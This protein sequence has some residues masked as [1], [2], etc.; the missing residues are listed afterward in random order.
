LARAPDATCG[1]ARHWSNGGRGLRQVAAA[2]RASRILPNLRTPP[3]TAVPRRT[4]SIC[5]SWRDASAS[6]PRPPRRSP[7]A[8]PLR[9]SR[10]KTWTGRRPRARR[11]A[12]RAQASAAPSPGSK[13]TVSQA[14]GRARTAAPMNVSSSISRSL[15]RALS[16]R[17]LLPCPSR[18]ERLSQG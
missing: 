10:R 17:D 18:S 13:S 9:A 3:R 4:A 2:H 7:A 15:T 12:F 1:A 6:M 14:P 11:G 16:R 5:G 8:L